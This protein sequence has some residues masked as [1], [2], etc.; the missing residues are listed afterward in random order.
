[1][2]IDVSRLSSGVNLPRE[3]SN[4]IMTNAQE[5]SA[6]MRLA[7]RVDMPGRGLTIP[8]LSG[9]AQA[10]WVDETDEKPV[11]RPTF[12]NKNMT[13]YTLAVIVPFSNQFKRD[14]QALYNAILDRLPG[15]LG[16]KFDATVLRDGDVPGSN[17][18]TLADVTTVSLK[19]DT[20]DGLVAA[21]GALSAAGHLLNGWALAPQGRGL[22]LQSRDENGRPLFINSASDGAVPMLLG[23]PVYLT[24][25]V[26]KADADGAGAGTEAQVGVVGDWTQ[27]QYGTVEGIQISMS[28][29]ATLTDG[30]NTINL[31]QRNMFAV[32][33]EVEIGF[34]ANKSAF[35][36]LTA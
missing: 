13:A 6:V 26:Y 9:D 7:K 10:D 35:R 33:A 32:R 23:A 27:A 17:F 31:W 18:D 11:S 34:T 21:D 30:E 25:S 16:A 20:Y 29:Q 12:S 24:R 4:E 8:V 3:V 36:R 28:D 14:G 5:Q 19:T 22:L 2:A 1:M 15:A